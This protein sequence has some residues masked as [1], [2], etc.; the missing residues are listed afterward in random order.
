MG[1][2]A[3]GWVNSRAVPVASKAD[4]P[5]LETLIL[6]VNDAKKDTSSTSGK[7]GDE[8]PIFC[9]WQWGILYQW[10]YGNDWDDDDDDDDDDVECGWMEGSNIHDM[11]L[12]R[13]TCRFH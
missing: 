6:V 7:D 9:R 10:Q 8:A 11:W 1:S 5:D 2:A 13:Y 12:F 3:N 4:W